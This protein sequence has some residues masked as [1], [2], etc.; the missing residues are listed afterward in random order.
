LC[1]AAALMA[2]GIATA[3]AAADDRDTCDNGKGGEAIAACSRLIGRNPKDTGAYN[4]N[5]ALELA[6]CPRYIRLV[7]ILPVL[8]RSDMKSKSRPR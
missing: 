5:Y 4:G 3:P 6:E 2:F 8:A 1:A 7:P